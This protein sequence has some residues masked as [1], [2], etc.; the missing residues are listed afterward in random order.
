MI[1]REQDN[2][3]NEK[4]IT[5]RKEDPNTVEKESEPIQPEEKEDKIQETQI[6]VIP[7]E[8]IINVLPQEENT[9]DNISNIEDKITDDTDS[10]IH[11]NPV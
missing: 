1:H 3:L 11:V 10:L 8:D 6:N 2:N 7:Q 9:Q 5:P 4:N